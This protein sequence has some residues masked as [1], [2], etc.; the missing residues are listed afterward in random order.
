MDHGPFDDLTRSLALE[1][2]PRRSVIRLLAGGALAGLAAHLGLAVDVV[3]KKR[4]ASKSKRRKSRPERNAHGA[5]QSEGKGKHKSKHHKKRKP[6]DPPPLPPGCEHCNPCQ[7]CQ[8]GACVPDPDLERVRCAGSGAACGYCQGGICAASVIPPCDDGTCPR[9]GYC[10]PGEKYCSDRESSTGYA[11]VG[12][13]D[14]CPGQKKCANGACIANSGCCEEDRPQCGRCDTATCQHGAWVCGGTC[15]SGEKRCGD[16]SCVP[17]DGCCGG[18]CG[19]GSVCCKG[20]C[21][22]LDDE[23]VRYACSLDGCCPLWFLCNDGRCDH[24][25][26][27]DSCD[28]PEL[29]PE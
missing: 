16:G 6:K 7:M 9:K 24:R 10:C 8:D 17:E 1:P 29:C 11:C 4:H 26:F 13:T 28:P 19:Y 2:G 5:L 18:N 12:E 22:N 25:C 15:C 20:A 23:G 14:C 27:Y 21:C 3:G